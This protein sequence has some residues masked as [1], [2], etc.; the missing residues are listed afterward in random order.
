VEHHGIE[1]A[2]GHVEQFHHQMCKISIMINAQNIEE[3]SSR[4]I[5][6]SPE[7]ISWQRQR[8]LDK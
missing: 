1:A 2:I 5:V 7:I 6:L 3:I 4:P 8:S